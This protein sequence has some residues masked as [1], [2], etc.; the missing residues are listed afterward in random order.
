MVLEIEVLESPNTPLPLTRL[1]DAIEEPR[2]V[3]QVWTSSPDGAEGWHEVTGWSDEGPVPAYAALVEDSGEGRA[4]LLFGG[5]H[6]IRLKP[7]SSP[8]PWDLQNPHQ[9][10]EPCL[11]LAADTPTTSEQPS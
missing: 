3:C 2:P 6:G 5:S 7:T 4:L 11:L 8:G 10:G 1:F 9:W